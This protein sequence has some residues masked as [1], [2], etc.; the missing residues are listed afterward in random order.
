VSHWHLQ[1]PVDGNIDFKMF[2][3]YYC[4]SC[5]NLWIWNRYLCFVEYKNK[6][7]WLPTRGIT[8]KCG[9]IYDVKVSAIPLWHTTI[10][11]NKQG[12]IGKNFRPRKIN[13]TSLQW[14]ILG[15]CPR[16]L[17]RIE[18]NFQRNWI[19]FFNP[20]YKTNFLPLYMVKMY[21]YIKILSPWTTS[22]WA[23][24]SI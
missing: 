22:R 17:K 5:W 20:Y 18:M 13:L 8:V 19:Q 23:T 16:I 4:V 14:Q 24:G 6:G 11:W 10:R 2:T 1:L 3:C 15:G 7:V 21:A 9:Q 12:R